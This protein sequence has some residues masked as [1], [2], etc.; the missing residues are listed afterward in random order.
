MAQ[1]AVYHT[2]LLERSAELAS[3][4]RQLDL[5]RTQASGRLGVVGGEAGVGK[6]TLVRTFCAQAGGARVLWGACDALF[7]P[8]PLGP[9][10]DIAATTGGELARLTGSRARPHEVAS[11]LIAELQGSS[12]TIVVLEDMQWADE[13][14]LDAVR[15]LTR[16]IEGAPGLVILTYR[17][18]EL[19]A[20][21][22]LR[23]V[24]GELPRQDSVFRIRV[25][26]LSADAVATLARPAGR[27]PEELYR[28][29]A[30]NP[31]FVTEALASSDEEIPS[32][33]RDA[34]LSRAARI[35]ADARGL[36]DA[37]AIAPPHADVWMLEA[38]AGDK[39]HAL[40]ECLASGMLARQNGS[41]AFHHELARLAIV[42]SIA[43]DRALTL[44]RRTLGA[45]IAPPNGSPDPA[46]LA[47][48]AEA[49]HDSAAQ[50][51]YARMAGERAAAVGA[52]REAAAQFQRALRASEALPAEQRAGLLEQLAQ[53]Y[54]V[55]NRAD[56]AIENQEE[57]IRLYAKAGDKPRHADALRKQS[58]LYMCGGRGADAEESIRLA[59]QLLEAMPESRELAF[60][61]SGLVMFHMNHDHAD[62]VLEAGRRA[63]ELAEK[64]DDLETVLHTLNS[65]GSMELVM[66]NAAG[67]EKLLRSLDMAAELGMDEHVGRA[68]INL[69]GAGAEMHMYDGFF[70]MTKAGAQ[71]C[72]EHGLELWRMWVLT[73]E[74]KAHLD[75]GDW[76]RATEV[77]EMVLNGEMG[78]LP[79]VSALPIIALVRARRGDPGVLP[80]LDEASVM[81]R[82]EGELQ[83]AVPVAAA[84]AEVAW[85]EGRPDEVRAETEEAFAK[86]TRQ[87]SWWKLGPLLLWRRRAGI[88]D[89]V[90]PRVPD[91]FRAE[92]DGDHA[93]A[94][95]L[96][97]ALGCD[98]D[99][100]LAL[101][102]SDDEELLRRSLTTLQ[103]LGARAT[104]AVVARKLRALGAQGIARGP[105]PAT[106]RNPAQLTEREVEVLELVGAGMR[107]SDIAR[108]LFLTT[109]TV[110][111]HVS[112]ILRKLGVDSRGQ[113]AAEAARLGLRSG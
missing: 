12:P 14:T 13:A 10:V 97:S 7:T 57:A 84:R 105:R 1:T 113:A 104:A 54:L 74:A 83:Y 22:P 112:S 25:Q 52:H 24:L 95:D 8:R 56:L 108:K 79:R 87:D 5:V 107:N 80:L 85:L 70:A 9:L 72:L 58:R 69:S 60:A 77:A 99:A 53:E 102:G 96:W 66:G 45:L 98:Y 21:H 46:R 48:H 49:A 55:V 81:A 41:V 16:R 30:G 47:H 111:H 86:A 63:L 50:L 4:A 26:R 90:D 62:G 6:T 43:P 33:V 19:G 20:S 94:A 67:K 11:A 40:G 82:R 61:Y 109:K 17:D 73:N 76:S 91:R 68:Y 101:A 36:L 32:T 89:A 110:D 64:Y 23:F 35:S 93:R 100:A 31:F 39:V 88:T 106:Q 51:R 18:D 34:V 59:I 29:T 103:R 44:H 37:V 28:K 42:E 65:V 71:F 78:Q 2:K 92:L 27:D 75:R 15:L 3:L 38:V